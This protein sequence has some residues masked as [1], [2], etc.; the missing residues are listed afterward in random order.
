MS[1]RALIPVSVLAALLSFSTA[2]AQVPEL[3]PIERYDGEVV[4]RATLRNA[5]DLMLLTQLSDDPWSH[6]PGIGAPSDW[7]LPRERLATLRAAGVPFEIFIPDVQAL[8]QAERE[9]LAQPQEAADWFAD[10]KD[11]AAINARLDSFVAARP[12]LC[13][14]VNLPVTTIQGRT[15]KGIRISRHPAGTSM[16]AFAF[17]GT[18]HAREWGGTMTAMWIIDRLVED[19]DTDARI[20]AI[21]DASEVF[22]FPVINPDGYLH[23]WSNNRLWRKNRRLNSGGSYGVDLNR[24]WGFQWGGQGASTQQS[25]ETYRGTSAFSEP[26]TR[27]YRDWATPRTNIAAHLDIHAYS[28][29][30]LWPW[31]YTA[32]LPVD[33]TSFDR[34]GASMHDAIQAIEGRDYIAGPVYTTIYPS[35]GGVCDWAYGA[36]G[37]LSYCVEVRDTGTYGFIMPPSEILPNVRENFAGA[38]AMMEETLKAC[39]ITLTVGPDV[40]MTA[41]TATPVRVSVAANV[42]TLLASNPVRLKW[43]VSGGAVQAVTMTLASGQWGASLPATACGNTLQWWVEAETNFSVTRWPSNAAMS[44]RSTSTGACGIEGDLDGDGVVGAGD[45]AFLLLHYGACTGCPS[46]LDGDGVV[47]AGDIAVLVLLFS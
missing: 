31:G 33:Q 37:Q 46:D 8:V 41:D 30:L 26:E 2:R 17:T 10:F 34:V 16:P 36:L 29:L 28:E 20:G 22:V 4:V 32:T 13:S 11:L 27:A 19:A 6:A 24:N 39:T 5:Q 25:S 45:I 3:E 15:I 21:L 9:R 44:S 43:K 7:R 23:S 35:S 12:D 14:I 38:L 40:I 42:G 18:Q 1:A 47:G